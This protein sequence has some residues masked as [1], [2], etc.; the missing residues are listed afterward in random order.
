[1]SVIT[2]DKSFYKQFLS[3]MVFIALQNL[4]VYSVNLADNIMLG[5]YS[6]EA[7]SGVALANQVQFLLQMIV[8]GVGEGVVVLASQYWGKKELRPIPH[9]GGIGARVALVTGALFM[10][11]GLVVP[12]Q[13][14]FILSKEEPVLNEGVA[15]MRIVCFTYLLYAATAVLLATMRSVENVRIGMYVSVM[16]L[17]VNISLNYCLIFGRLGLPRLGVR[18][19]AI[20]TLIARA[21]EFC[22]V[23]FYVLRIDTKLRMKLGQLLAI[24]R[25]LTGDYV[26][27]ATPVI[28]SGLSWGIAQFIQTSILG[29]MGSAALAANSIAATLFSILSVVFYGSGSASAVQIASVVGSGDH[30]KIREYVNTLQLIFL[31]NG[32]LTGAAI[33]LLRMPII[34]LY[35][36]VTGEAAALANQFLTVLS[37]TSI[38]SAYQAP[39]LTGIVR[40]GGNTKFVFYNDLVFQW[41]MVITLSLLAEYVWHLPPVWVFFFLKSDQLVKCI[42]AVFEVNSYRWIRKLTRDKLPGHDP[43]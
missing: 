5:N 21:V 1:M 11:A 12:R 37:I 2:R 30:S 41:G 25:T 29:H 26:R 17:V 33:Y 8:S 20:A 9:I 14:L 40:G 42:V 43:A 22:V 24:D 4:I 32:L 27:V 7:L 31:L 18:G 28:L 6:Q 13:I 10:L 36:E 38:G 39:C 35:R 19:A 16:A 23:L 3:L 34:G 15:Y